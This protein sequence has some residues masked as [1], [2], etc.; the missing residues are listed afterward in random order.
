MSY[1]IYK[2]TSTVSGDNNTYV[3]STKNYNTRLYNHKCVGNKGTV[4]TKFYRH[5]NRVGWDKAVLSVLEQ[6]V[7][8]DSRF[9]RE[10]HYITTLRPSLN[11]NRAYVPLCPHKVKKYRCTK[12]CSDER[13]KQNHYCSICN[14]QSFASKQALKLHYKSQKHKYNLK[15]L[16]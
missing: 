15:P 16:F 1:K 7:A 2:I 5:F 9:V 12:G 4:N 13:D 8:E 11:S 10:Q 3:G 14:F 6:D